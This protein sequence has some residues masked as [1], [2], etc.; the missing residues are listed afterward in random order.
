MATE[1]LSVQVACRVL[2]V[3]E[4]GYYAWRTRPRSARAGRHAWLTDRIRAVHAASRG[5]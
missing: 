2:G 1:G 4:S 5:T 3:S